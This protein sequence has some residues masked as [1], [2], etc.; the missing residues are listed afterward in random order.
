M[1][2]RDRIAAHSKV[3]K[4]LSPG[5]WVKQNKHCDE[6]ARNVDKKARDIV[7]YAVS[8]FFHRIVPKL[9]L[10]A[11]TQICD[12][13]EQTGMK[14]LYIS[15]LNVMNSLS[16]SILLSPQHSTYWPRF[17]I[18]LWLLLYIKSICF[19]WNICNF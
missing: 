13:L 3:K 6:L 4:S 8:S 2:T 11:Q 15:A 19:C 7:Q 18:P 12:S 17:D 16:L 5:D 14:A 1:F 9:M 10:Q